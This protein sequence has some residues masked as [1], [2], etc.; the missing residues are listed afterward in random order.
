[1]K[2]AD[3]IIIDY[4][5]QYVEMSISTLILVINILKIGIDYSKKKYFDLIF[6]ILSTKSIIVIL[7]I[8]LFI[9]LFAIQKSN[10]TGAIHYTNTNK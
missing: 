7:F 5:I 9:Y 1:M 4:L 2:H 8:H 6:N 3:D 10:W